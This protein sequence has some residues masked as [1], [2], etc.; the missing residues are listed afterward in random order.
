MHNAAKAT[1][2]SID[3]LLAYLANSIAD[4]SAEVVPAAVPPSVPPSVSEVPVDVVPTAVPPSASFSLTDLPADVIRSSI[5]PY[6]TA[7]DV[8]AIVKANKY[9]FDS[10]NNWKFIKAQFRRLGIP[11]VALTEDIKTYVRNLWYLYLVCKRVLSRQSMRHEVQRIYPEDLDDPRKL[12]CLSGELGAV[13]YASHNGNAE[14]WQT[15]Q[16]NLPREFFIALSGSA[17]ALT[18]RTDIPFDFHGVGRDGITLA[19]ACGLGGTPNALRVAVRNGADINATDEFNITVAHSGGFSGN[20]DILQTLQSLGVNLQTVALDEYGQPLTFA[21]AISGQPIMLAECHRLGLIVPSVRDVMGYQ[22]EH[23]CA[24]TDNPIMLHEAQRYGADLNA[25][26]E[27]MESVAHICAENDNPNVLRMLVQLGVMLRNIGQNM[28]GRTVGHICAKKGNLVTIGIVVDEGVDLTIADND[29][30]T[31]VHHIAQYGTV[32]LFE[33]AI[34]GLSS[35]FL[36]NARD[37]D[38]EGAICYCVRNRDENILHVA[39]HYGLNFDVRNTAGD[40]PAHI[41]ARE[42]TV[43]MLLTLQRLGVNLHRVRAN[44]LGRTLLHCSAENEDPEMLRI[45]ASNYTSD[46]NSSDIDGQ[47]AAHLCAGK[48]KNPDVLQ[49]AVNSNLDMTAIDNQGQTVLMHCAQNENPQM[50]QKGVALGLD[51]TATDNAG[52]SVVHHCA[53]NVNPDAIRTA[54]RLGFDLTAQDNV[55]KTVLHYAAGTGSV[56]LLDAVARLVNPMIYLQRDANNFSIIDYAQQSGVPEQG[57]MAT[58]LV[59]YAIQ[60]NHVYQ[61]SRFLLFG[62]IRQDRIGIQPEDIP[63]EVMDSIVR[64]S[65]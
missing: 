34:A 49:Q 23:V 11:E 26:S 9:L 41:C 13:Q 24:M 54:Y 45:V 33:R 35:D 48:N 20:P 44:D 15:Q 32:E 22:L 3:E 58:R 30:F 40:S 37:N 52:R 21:C 43:Q 18:T 42:G 55:R 51:R 64:H 59:Q 16:D 19:H 27:D 17:E 4:V 39:R 6:L 8:K 38:E 14:Y 7:K 57:Q 53:E 29:N 63:D 46:I 12:L 2:E 61:S 5:T 28:S 36:L 62:M 56:E 10:L 47:T 50:L 60:Y 25:I 1:R 31:A 65:M